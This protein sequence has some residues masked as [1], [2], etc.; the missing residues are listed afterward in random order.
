[1]KLSLHPSVGVARLGNSPDQICLSPQTIGGLPFDA[2][3]HGNQLG[4]V[5]HFKDA[6]GRI[7]RQGQVFKIYDENG[8]EITYDNPNVE[9]ITWEVHL[10]NKKAAWYQYSELKGN[11]MY[12]NNSYKEWGVPWRNPDVVGEKERQTLIVDPG[13]RRITG[14]NQKISFT[15]ED[16]QRDYPAQF[17]PADVKYGTAVKTLGDLLTDDK[18]RLVV[19]G[20]LG[21]AGG[22]LP[23]TSYGGSST[24]HDDISDGPVSCLV[25][26]KN[27]STIW[28]LKA[29]VIIG[30]PDFAPEIVNIST[31]SDTMFDVG[32][33]NFNMVPDMRKKIGEGEEEKEIWNEDYEASFKHDILPIIDRISRYQWV[34]NVPSMMAFCSF[35]F[36]YGDN[37]PANR[38]NREQ[39]FSYFRRPDGVPP[40]DP[41]EDQPQQ[42]LWKLNGDDY[43]PGMPL[44]AGSN[45]V[46]E[47]NI[48]KFLA[49][50]ETQ[51]FLMGQWAKGKFHREKEQA[52]NPISPVD[53]ASVGNCVGLPMCPGIEVTWSMQNKN[54]Y[55]APYVIRARQRNYFETGLSPE[56]DECVGGGCEPGD[57]TKRM[58]C[59]WQADFFQCT[60]QY[61]NFTIPTQNKDNGKRLPPTYYSYWWPPQSPWDVL[62]G[63]IT[64]EGQAASDMPAGVQ[65]NYQRGI[66]SFVQMVEHWSALGFIRDQNASQE[67]FP[68]LVETERVNE[69][70]TFRDVPV[71][72]ISGNPKD[73]EVT[74]PVFFIEESKPE[75]KKKSA[76]GAALVAHLE[77]LAFKPIA[78]AA[79]GLPLPRSGSRNRY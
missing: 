7:K 44:N 23:L 74:I 11:L 49:L 59:P 64:V 46:S 9:S 73:D 75:I 55:E 16:V 72:E 77:T 25:K 71:G 27:E 63:E 26:F 1:M 34:A 39:Y 68:Y 37:S 53:A 4:P 67:G 62:T 45:P 36:D 30:S 33:R 78:V 5:K 24:W 12:P 10:A 41:P 52:S 28:A 61:I 51:Y 40:L 69:L 66:N 43:F 19:L 18:G 65:V 54:V 22:D 48:V 15:K 60:I 42:Q 20:G 13:P 6:T 8:V 76:R 14:P 50:D 57:L 2:D 56:R 21:N 31:L 58:A 79:E 32:V 29:W 17:P 3:E 70:F 47:V 38:N 35:Q